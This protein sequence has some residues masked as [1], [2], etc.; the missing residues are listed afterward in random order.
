MFGLGIET[1]MR[2]YRKQRSATW[3]KFCCA[4]RKAF[5]SNYSSGKVQMT[6]NMGLIK[7]EKRK[8]L[9]EGKEAPSLSILFY[10]FYP[11]LKLLFMLQ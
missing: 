9:G 1:Q 6:T 7:N 8:P 3:H 4:Q 2:S 5:L 11:L 10:F